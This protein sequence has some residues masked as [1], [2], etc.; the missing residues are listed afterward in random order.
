MR[1]CVVD[2]KKSTTIVPSDKWQPLQGLL[3]KWFHIQP[4]EIDDMLID[5]L[6]GWVDEANQQIDAQN[7]AIKD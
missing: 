5:E 3:A 1:W 6:L 7:K 4:S 2:F